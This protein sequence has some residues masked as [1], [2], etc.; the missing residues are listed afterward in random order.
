METEL[1]HLCCL[2]LLLKLLE[3]LCCDKADWLVPCDQLRA[4][5]HSGQDDVP[6]KTANTDQE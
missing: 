5:G 3:L 2:S 6:A 4:S 1:A